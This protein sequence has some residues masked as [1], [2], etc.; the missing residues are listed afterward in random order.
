MFRICNNKRNG[1]LEDGPKMDYLKFGSGIGLS[2]SHTAPLKRRMSFGP[3]ESRKCGN[4][5]QLVLGNSK[6]ETFSLFG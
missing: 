6:S 3:G 2:V 5:R 4:C 1:R